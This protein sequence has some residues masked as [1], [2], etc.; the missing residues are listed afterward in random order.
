MNVK[1]KFHCTIFTQHLGVLQLHYVYL[2]L[3]AWNFVCDRN[4][5]LILDISENPQ[6]LD[7]PWKYL[8]YGIMLRRHTMDS[9]S[10]LIISVLV[11]SPE[12]LVVELQLSG[13]PGCQPRSRTRVV[14]HNSVTRYTDIT[15]SCSCN[16][17]TQISQTHVVYLNSVTRYTDITDLCSLS[18]LCNEIT[19]ISP[20]HVVYLNSV[21]R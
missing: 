4:F 19:Q 3:N 8:L 14:Y 13:L 7:N 11:G 6:K 5:L 20:T 9:H 16:E 15:G 1:T 2:Y 21:T 12:S 10:S 17:I 18:Q